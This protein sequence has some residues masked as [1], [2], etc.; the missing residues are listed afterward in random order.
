MMAS[1]VAT[2]D[3]RA[4]GLDVALSLR[5]SLYVRFAKQIMHPAFL[6]RRPAQTQKHRAPP[7]SAFRLARSQCRFPLDVPA[8][9]DDNGRHSRA[10]EFRHTTISLM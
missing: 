3:G 9:A 5:S 2:S 8:G 6:F 10:I 1:I 7:I 4:L